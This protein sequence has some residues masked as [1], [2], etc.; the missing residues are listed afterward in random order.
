MGRNVIKVYQGLDMIYSYSSPSCQLQCLFLFVC[1][2]CFFFFFLFCF[3]RSRGWMGNSSVKEFSLSLCDTCPLRLQ[4]TCKTPFPWYQKYIHLNE[5]QFI[6]PKLI[7]E[8]K[9]YH[10][11]YLVL[12]NTGV[13]FHSMRHHSGTPWLLCHLCESHHYSCRLP[14]IL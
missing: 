5:L 4:I 10:L 2:F 14:L 9:M 11:L 3:F 12:G 1:F 8:E 6:I 13:Y 7:R